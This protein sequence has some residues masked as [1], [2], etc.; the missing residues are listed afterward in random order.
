MPT[1][2]VVPNRMYFDIVPLLSHILLSRGDCRGCAEAYQHLGIA[3]T[4][5]RHHAGLP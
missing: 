3:L 4:Y 5:A 1:P 2:G